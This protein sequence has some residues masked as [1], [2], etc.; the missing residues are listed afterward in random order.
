MRWHFSPFMAATI[1]C[2]IRKQILLCEVIG[3][4]RAMRHPQAVR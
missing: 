3:C 4:L 2:E 1:S